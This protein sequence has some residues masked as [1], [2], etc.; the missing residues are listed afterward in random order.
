[1]R[2]HPLQ[3]LSGEA[4]DEAAREADRWV[5][6]HILVGAFMYP[7]AGLVATLIMPHEPSLPFYA[8]WA[9]VF[10]ATILGLIRFLF[11]WNFDDLYGRRRVLWQRV[12]WSCTLLT[13]LSWSASTGVV[14]AHHGL[15]VPGVMCLM[16]TAGVATG[17]Y[18]VFAPLF[19]F[20][21][22]SYALLCLPLMPGLV[23][24]DAQGWPMAAA[25]GIYVAYLI[26]QSRI[27]YR[28]F[29]DHIVGGIRL[30]RGVEEVERVNRE[31][32]LRSEQAAAGSAAKSRF[33]A[34][35]SHELRTPLHGILGNA[36]LLLA[37]GMADKE[38]RLCRAIYDSGRSLL[39]LVD[40]ILDLSRVEAGQMRLEVEAIDIRDLVGKVGE[41]LRRLGQPKGLEVE[42]AVTD[43]VP[44][45]VMVDG[46]RFK[47]ILLNLGANAVKFT[48]RGLVR[49][50]LRYHAD[51]DPPII[52]AYISDTGPGIPPGQEAMIFDDFVQ[53]ESG[54]DRR[55]EGSGLGLAICKRLVEVMGGDIGVESVQ[56]VGS[57]FWFS[58]PAREAYQTGQR[59]LTGGRGATAREPARTGARI[60]IVDDNASNRQLAVEQVGYLGHQ[61]ESADNAETALERLASERFD[62]VLLDCQMPGIDG[63]E[64]AQRI[65]ELKNR[66]RLVPIVAV[67]ANAMPEERA[68]CLQAGMDDYVSK[69]LNL[70]RLRG[71]L[72]T[73]IGEES[74]VTDDP[75]P[76]AEDVVPAA[77]DIEPTRAQELRNLV[78]SVG[79]DAVRSVFESFDSDLERRMGELSRALAVDDFEAGARAAH[80][81]K[82]MFVDMGFR[83]LTEVAAGMETRLR[84]GLAVEEGDL[85]LVRNQAV[86]GR[87]ALADMIGITAPV[88]PRY[89]DQSA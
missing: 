26:F 20:A 29:W 67:T 62:L 21:C 10:V 87:D 65:R 71:L 63:Y 81:M 37:S 45:R 46:E 8:L 84:R 32:Q 70:D 53:L 30:R 54:T 77:D 3:S 15:S 76:P 28:E 43:D 74:P 55:Y 4:R 25:A 79:A 18:A 27:R 89:R 31:L 72:A 85:E 48:E 7:V 47:Q 73:W 17:V 33:I 41:V 23:M 57:T 64:A 58:V 60:L 51:L 34:N 14:L 86:A 59:R 13:I 19:W 42:T 6:R 16:I 78:Q 69:P 22:V 49:V 44:R 12:V 1:M 66:N 80:A 61:A 11:A 83:R 56:Q 40:D 52:E 35:T 82:G 75:A 36:E 68:R 50:A 38:E 24:G 2:E 39:R 5:A 9:Y 88:P